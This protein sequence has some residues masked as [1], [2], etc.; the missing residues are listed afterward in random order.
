MAM[1]YNKTMSDYR[2]ALRFKMFEQ[3]VFTD[4]KSSSLKI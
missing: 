4:V 1:D 2:D 3:P